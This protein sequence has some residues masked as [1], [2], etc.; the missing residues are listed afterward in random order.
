MDNLTHSLIGVLLARAGLNRLAPRATALAVGAAN[1]PDLDIVSGVGGSLCYLAH[2]R[3][4][5]HA[6]FWAPLVALAP[7]PVWWWFTRKQSPGARQWAGAYVVS[8]VAVISHLMLD[9]LNVYGIRLK[10]PFSGEWLRLDLVHI[11]DVWLWAVLLVCA[12]GPLLGRLVDS[13]MGGK[14]SPASGRGMAWLGLVA[15]AG[16]LGLRYQ[17]HDQAL[18]VMDARLYHGETARH[19]TA[20]PSA[21]NPWQW[22]GLVETDGAWRVVPVN[23]LREF[24]PDAAR[25]FYK[26]DISRVKAAVMATETGRVLLDFAQCALWS[27]T[28]VPAPEGGVSVKIYDL[29]FG[30]P[31]ENMF[32][33]EVVLDAAGRVVREGRAT[34]TMERGKP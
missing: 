32:A 34:G 24:D 5:T 1:L 8:L 29:R 22:T 18:R 16:Y 33:I 3:G 28:P 14:R 21:A 30:L 31:E 19:L 15:V 23:L 9:W 25:V 13:E 27:V 20:L 6:M 26:P 17:L 10:L 12:L 2:H 4:F 11:V 7:L